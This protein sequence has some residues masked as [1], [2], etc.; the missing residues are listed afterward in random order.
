MQNEWEKLRE[1]W[2]EFA[3][4]VSRTFDETSR[5]LERIR[6]SWVKSDKVKRLRA[7]WHVPKDT[8]VKSQVADKRP[9]Y[10]IRK[11]IR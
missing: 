1:V 11:V 4:L 8:R 10:F 5:V 3:L 7:S 9:K 6:K 2:E